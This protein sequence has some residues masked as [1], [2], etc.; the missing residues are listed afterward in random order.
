[1][2]LKLIYWT[3]LGIFIVALGLWAWRESDGVRAAL[4]SSREITAKD[5]MLSSDLKRIEQRWASAE[6]Q[7]LAHR[8]ELAA[9]Q[10]QAVAATPSKMP[11][12]PARPLSILELIRNEPD[13]EAF[14]LESRRSELAAKY[15]PLFRT[16]GLTGESVKKFQDIYIKR[17]ATRMDLS[18]VLRTKH[19]TEDRAAVE[20]LKAAA[21]ADYV[22]EQHTL[23]GDAGYEKLRQYD[24]FS[25]WRN[26]V[27]AIA[28]MAA[29]EHV[30]FSAAQ[31][32]ALVQAMVDAGTHPVI[33]GVATGEGI[34]W[35][36]VDDQARAILSPEQF[37]VFSTMDPGPTRGG[38]LQDRLYELANMANKADTQASSS[39]VTSPAPAH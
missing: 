5:A 9:L 12:P 38:L 31:A 20:K 29:V 32:D 10:K 35:K 30:P 16:L 34:D 15:G 14:F 1:M 25:G 18:E 3:A 2:N 28:G 22:A 13:A 23:L 33:N 24:W 6:R 8:N 26:M 36:K 4:V 27:S 19:T 7:Q 11:P 17:E 39:A 21:E 37:V